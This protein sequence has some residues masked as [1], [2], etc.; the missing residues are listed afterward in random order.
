MRG[1]GEGGLDVT[2]DIKVKNYK[3]NTT[4]EYLIHALLKHSKTTLGQALSALSNLCN[5][6]DS[7]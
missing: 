1:G 4:F 7:I 2:I 6:L 5:Y 3:Q